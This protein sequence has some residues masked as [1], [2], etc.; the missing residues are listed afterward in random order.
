[1]VGV[2]A[3]VIFH[4]AADR[5]RHLVEA[6]Q[7]VLHRLGRQVGVVGERLV[8]LV[9]VGRVVLVVMDLHRLRVDVGL[10]RVEGVRQRRQLIRHRDPPLLVG[11]GW[12]VR[13]G[14]SPPGPAPYSVRS[15]KAPARGAWKGRARFCRGGP[16][17]PPRAPTQGRLYRSFSST[18]STCL[19][20]LGS[21][22]FIR[23]FSV[24]SF[25]LFE[26]V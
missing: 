2:A 8:Q 23:S 15:A 6:A 21:Y 13:L 14:R 22:F 3:A 4:R 17:W 26:V 11:W 12:R 7:Q 5:L 19:R 20:T 24:E 25:L 18:N 1:M 16:M 9:V 10:E